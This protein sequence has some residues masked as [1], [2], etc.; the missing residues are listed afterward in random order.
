[1]FQMCYSL[2]FT[3]TIIFVYEELGGGGHKNDFHI[4][5]LKYM[6]LRSNPFANKCLVFIKRQYINP[7]YVY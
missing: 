5:S 1:M 3:K 2:W 6:Y 7:V 4:F